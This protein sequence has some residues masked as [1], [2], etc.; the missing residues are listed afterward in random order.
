M[1]LFLLFES[2]FCSRSVHL[3][4]FNGFAPYF[5]PREVFYLAQDHGY[6]CFYTGDS[7]LKKKSAQIVPLL[8]F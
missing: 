8:L 6:L 1:T 7:R 3:L 4:P 5:C 2:S